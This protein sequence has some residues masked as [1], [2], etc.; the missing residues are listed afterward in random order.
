MLNEYTRETILFPWSE[1]MKKDKIITKYIENGGTIEE[2][3]QKVLQVKKC[4]CCNFPEVVFVDCYLDESEK[5]CVVG[6]CKKCFILHDDDK[7]FL[8][9]LISR[10]KQD[11]RFDSSSYS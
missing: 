7:Y 8:S 4:T 11:L 3:K 9:K 10:I 2:L 1:K 6:L 5:L